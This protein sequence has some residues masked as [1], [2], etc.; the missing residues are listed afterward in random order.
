MPT[1]NGHGFQ[2]FDT[3]QNK[4]SI[5]LE[6][7]YRFLR[8]R[9][10]PRAEGEIR[11]DLLYDLYFGIRT[12]GGSGWLH[13]DNNPRSR[14]ASAPT[15]VDESNILKVPITLGG[16]TATSY[17]FA[18][19]G[20]EGNALIA[21]LHAP[22]A[23]DG[24]VLFNF[25]MGS[26]GA[27]PDDPGTNGESTSL[28]GDGKGLVERGAGGGALA[29]V[30]LSDI[31]RID[32]SGVYDK[33]QNGRDLDDRPACNLPPEVVPAFQRRLGGDGW[34]AVAVVY[35]DNASEIEKAV[36]DLRAFLKGRTP[37][38][39]LAA[40]QAEWAAWRR[41]IP[42]EIDRTL[43]ADE[44]KVWRQG[45][46][47]LRMG[48]V[49]EPNTAA[50]KN[51]G[52]VLAS[53]PPGGWHTGWVR[54]ALYGIVALARA[55]YHA[56]ARA[57]LE[58]LLNAE[59]VGKHPNIDYRG[60]VNGADYRISLVRYFGT[61]QEEADHNQ[62]GP[63][64]ETDGWGMTLWAARQYVDA[65]LD[66]GWLEKPTR[67]GTVYE[68][69][70]QGVADA[71]E[72]NLESNGIVAADTSIWEVH[73][74]KRK[75]YAYTTLAAIRGFCDMATLAA[76]L[77]RAEDVKKYQALAARVQQGFL[78]SFLDR[79][80]AIAGTVEQLQQS[81]YGDAAVV[82]AFTWNIIDPMGRTGQQTL[83]LL[84]RLRVESGGFKRIEAGKD[85][86]DNNEWILI[87]LR[88]SDAMR[89]AGRVEQANALVNLVVEKSINNY[90]LLPELYNAI[91]AEGEIGA[92]TG[93][94]PMV[95]YGGGAF[96]LTMFDRAGLIEPNDCGTSVVTD[97]GVVTTAD[98]GGLIGGG[99]GPG[100]PDGPAPRT[101][102]CLCSAGRRG[103]DPAEQRAIALF[104]LCLC[105]LLYGT[106]ARAW[107]RS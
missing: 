42:M 52:M 37:E 59:P 53:L 5:F 17:F 98:G 81:Q 13:T 68:A 36:A 76:R 105:G 20:Y 60:Y 86:Y 97:M 100:G 25:H 89:R 80:G 40:A 33:V 71:L 14:P 21:L 23:S 61:G 79:D 39:I 74:A 104:L 66:P 101:T 103:P 55:G 8:A 75:H 48:Q 19:Y 54:D 16:V 50:R 27:N 38:Q 99:N 32:C 35:T 94:I 43:S 34:M 47:V 45:E 92:Y 57:G 12:G 6:H 82:E 9:P 62:D 90:Y 30:A 18:P 72:K 84:D 65:A 49:R 88:M 31:T 91:R 29:Y 107:R 96:I 15:Y 51:N 95:G 78:G 2:V 1:G 44:R 106:R 87:D 24:Y 67:A 4:L 3:S 56:E 73:W 93:S 28:L 69:L 102:A 10:D 7:P 83:K 63:N 85:S 26:P 46:A 11:R 22:G 70:K 58:F 77:K 41:P 64:I